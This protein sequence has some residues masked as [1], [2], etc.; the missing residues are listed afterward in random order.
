MVRPRKHARCAMTLQLEHSE[1]PQRAAAREFLAEGIGLVAVIPDGSKRPVGKWKEFQERRATT[2]ELDTWYAPGSTLGVAVV[3]GAVS[4]NLEMAEVEGRAT[5]RIPEI[6]QLAQDTGLGELWARLCGGWLEQSP[7]DGWH[8]LYRV[9]WPEGTKT[10]GNQ[11]L[12]KGANGEVLAET[13]G[14]GGYCIVAPTNGSVHPTGK[15]WTRIVGGPGSVPRVSV[16]ERE[17]FHALLAT[18]QPQTPTVGFNQPHR[19]PIQQTGSTSPGDDFEQQIDWAEILQPKG[20]TLVT[21]HGQTRHWRRPGKSIGMS[22]TTGHA[23]DRD[24]LFVF[25]TST[26]FKQETP[27]TKF[28]AYALLNHG[29]DFK[30]AA[31]ALRTQGFGSERGPSS[32]HTV[33]PSTGEPEQPRSY[34]DGSFDAAWLMEQEFPTIRYVVKDLIPEGLTILAGPPKIGKSWLVLGVAL[35]ASCGQPALGCIHTEQ[36]PVLYGALEDG[37]RRLQSRLAALGAT[38]P[39]RNLT[40]ITTAPSTDIVHIIAE[41]L[42]A[43]AGEAPVV[44]LDTWGKCVRPA[45]GGETTYE[46]DYKVAGGLKALADAHPGS[47]IVV[48]H[49]TRKAQPADFIDA[50]SGT[51]GIAGAADTVLVL[52]RGRGE[53]TGTLSATSRDT[54]EGEYRISLDGVGRWTLDGG[55]LEAAAE[56][57]QMIKATAGVGDRMTEVIEAVHRFPEGISPKDLKILLTSMPPDDVDTYLHRAWTANRIMRV[58]RG[59]YAPTPAV[60]G[61]QTYTTATL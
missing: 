26:E 1:T 28:G 8:W 13:R 38:N 6:A 58:K 53:N 45:V 60:S 47:S 49:H 27:Y 51:Q 54:K 18:L 55:S 57:E 48:V 59:L 2:A 42:N 56:A 50:V 29:G 23:E 16:D 46:R 5:D 44:F 22:A 11:K 12:A 4:G 15:P 9:D 31:A 34:L 10:P 7:S 33:G 30:A 52:R 19:T 61:Q 14:E 21:Q 35:A 43:H 17:A 41:Y 36:R 40:F 3:T 24:R 37:K 39:S 20:W 32:I 25:T